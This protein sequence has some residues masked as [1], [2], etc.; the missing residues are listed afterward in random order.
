MSISFSDENEERFIT[1]TTILPEDTAEVSLR[2]RTLRE[3]I[4]QQKV[5]ENLSVFIKAAKMRGEPLD[6]VL[7]HVPRD[8]ARQLLPRSLQTRWASICA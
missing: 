8:L 4:G 6:H 3:H 2:P 1:S 5:K 7:L